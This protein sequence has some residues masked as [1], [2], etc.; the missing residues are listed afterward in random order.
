MAAQTL[1]MPSAFLVKESAHAHTR[2]EFPEQTIQH[3]AQ[4]PRASQRAQSSACAQQE[5]YAPP[6]RPFSPRPAPL[7]PQAKP[8]QSDSLALVSSQDKYISLR[9]QSQFAS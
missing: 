3:T 8:K 2:R 4:R 6:A 5:S 7:E 9:V 1:P